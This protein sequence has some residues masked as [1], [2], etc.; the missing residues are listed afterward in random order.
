[1]Q[2][3]FETYWAYAQ[4]VT[5]WTNALERR[6]PADDREPLARVDLHVAQPRQVEHDPLVDRAEPRHVVAPVCAR[7]GAGRSPAARTTSCISEVVTAR[8]TTA[9]RASIMPFQTAR[10]SS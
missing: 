10:A 2:E 5:G 3:T 4:G 9:G 7:R 1:M 8:T 6:A